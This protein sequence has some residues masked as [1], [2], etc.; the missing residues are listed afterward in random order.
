MNRP[1]RFICLD[2]GCNFDT[3][4]VVKESRGEFWG[5]PCCEAMS[6]CPSCGSESFWEADEV[7]EEEVEE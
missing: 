1:Y 4:Q 7:E 5:I 6:Y 2:C 3:P